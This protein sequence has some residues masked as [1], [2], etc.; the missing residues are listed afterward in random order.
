MGT[1]RGLLGH[2]GPI[3]DVP[4]DWIDPLH[5]YQLL[6]NGCCHGV[7]WFLGEQIRKGG[8]DN[9]NFINLM[10]C[11]GCRIV[12]PETSIN[13]REKERS[14]VNKM[15]SHR[16]GQVSLTLAGI[17]W[18]FDVWSTLYVYWIILHRLILHL[19]AACVDLEGV[20]YFFHLQDLSR[21]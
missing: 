8:R 15:S 11:A 6:N 7:W 12:P 18:L 17:S 5:F 13:G 2:S 3:V 21:L 1:S 4:F 14:N 20:S 16:I 19:S 10:P 9:R